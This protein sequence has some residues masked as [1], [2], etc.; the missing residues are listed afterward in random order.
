MKNI[1]TIAFKERAGKPGGGKGYLGSEE[2]AFT[3][4][5]HQDQNIMQK[6][7]KSEIISNETKGTV[8]DNYRIRIEGTHNGK[9]WIYEDQGK[10]QSGTYY[11]NDTPL[12][13]FFWE[14]GNYSCDCNRLKFILPN[15]NVMGDY[16][17]GNT[18]FIDRII[19]LDRPD[20][21]IL[22]LNET[23]KNIS[24][25]IIYDTTQITSPQNAS[26]PKP[27]LCHTLA[28]GADAPLLV[29]NSD[30][31]NRL[32]DTLTKGANQTTGFVGDIALP[33]NVLIRR[34][35]PLE[36]ER[37]QGFPDNFTNI[38]GASDSK[39]YAALGNSMT[40]QV[41]QWIGQRI[42]LVDDAMKELAQRTERTNE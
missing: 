21:P 22:E 37:L 35:T 28:K 31:N 12:M 1:P 34:L 4:S 24:K 11:I 25:P 27:N 8:W 18:I 42:Q 36:C 26:N 16:K 14:E 3:L 15:W 39:R 6:I 33:Q 19:P 32:A 40:V 20:I 41:M 30:G 10:D 13:Y 7:D 29:E 17:C 9:A 38:P 23:E 2:L 5:R